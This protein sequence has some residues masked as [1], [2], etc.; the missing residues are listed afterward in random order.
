MPGAAWEL[1]QEIGACML[2]ALVLTPCQTHHPRAEKGIL[3]TTPDTTPAPPTP[4]YLSWMMPGLLCMDPKVWG[5][6]RL[7]FDAASG[8]H[9]PPSWLVQRRTA[10]CGATRG[11]S[12]ASESPFP[13]VALRAH[14]EPHHQ[15]AALLSL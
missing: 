3:R 11:L 15:V 14:H 7:Y 1:G 5:E 2:D 9:G 8:P 12:V 10:S 4:V 6:Q 13:A